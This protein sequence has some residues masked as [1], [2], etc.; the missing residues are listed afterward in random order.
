[1]VRNYPL[2]S[3]YENAFKAAQAAEAAKAQWKFWEYIDFLF[4]N[5]N[6][7]DVDSLKKYATQVGLDRKRFD[8]ELDS[9]KYEPVVRR[10]MEAG[11]NYGIDVTPTFYINGVILTDYSAEGLRDAIEKAFARAKRS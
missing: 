1:M 7:L 2:T 11:D 8:T 3:R 10:D 9:G 6:A 5:Q 4:K